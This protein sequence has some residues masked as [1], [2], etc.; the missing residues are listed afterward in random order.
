[1]KLP[2]IIRDALSHRCTIG[3]TEEYHPD[4]EQMPA[5]YYLNDA[6]LPNVEA[7]ISL[8]IGRG[9]YSDDHVFMIRF[10]T[11]ASTH[12]DVTR[13]QINILRVSRYLSEGET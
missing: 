12:D 3:D 5:W 10:D 2:T 6:S 11:D 9:A 1:M 4:D 8:I 13:V 7:L